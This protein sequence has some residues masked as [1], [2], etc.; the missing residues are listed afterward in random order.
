LQAAKNVDT[1]E[2]VSSGFEGERLAAELRKR[3]IV[4][5][6]KLN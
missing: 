6:S 3:R 1:S 2:L 4:T 5:I